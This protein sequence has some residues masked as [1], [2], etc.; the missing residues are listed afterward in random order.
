MHWDDLGENKF[1]KH[2]PS[3]WWGRSPQ[4]FIPTSKVFS[5]LVLIFQSACVAR[6]KR[7][8]LLCHIILNSSYFLFTLGVKKGM[9]KKHQCFELWMLYSE[10]IASD[11]ITSF[12]SVFQMKNQNSITRH[13]RHYSLQLL[14]GL[15]PTFD[16]K[17]FRYGLKGCIQSVYLCFVCNKEYSRTLFASSCPYKHICTVWFLKS[18]WC[19]KCPFTQL[20]LILF[21]TTL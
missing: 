2:M 16:F 21:F 17:T 4:H 5:E 15:V 18:L 14:P 12:L 9:K 19:W 20:F 8:I 1:T 6:V 7:W 11:G 3:P 13:V 10:Y